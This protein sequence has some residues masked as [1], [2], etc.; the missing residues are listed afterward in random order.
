MEE[1]IHDSDRLLCSYLAADGAIERYARVAIVEHV[2]QYTSI[3]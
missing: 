3:L 1:V 2:M